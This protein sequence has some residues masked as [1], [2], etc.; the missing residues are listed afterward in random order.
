MNF[1]IERYP[2]SYIN[3]MQDNELK[4]TYKGSFYPKLPLE[5]LFRRQR[6][7]GRR[8]PSD[9]LRVTPSLAVRSA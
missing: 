6:L 7:G 3:P 5:N 9:A 4:F 2:K 1:V 8:D